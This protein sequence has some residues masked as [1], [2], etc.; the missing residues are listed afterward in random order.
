M[1]KTQTTIIANEE[2]RKQKLKK[3]K[4]YENNKEIWIKME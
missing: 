3:G 4:D 2:E 1:R